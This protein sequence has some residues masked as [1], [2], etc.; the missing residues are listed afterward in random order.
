LRGLTVFSVPAVYEE[1]FGLYVI[2]AMACG[3]P[4]V[5]PDAAAFSEILAATGGGLAVPPRDA[6]ALALAWKKLLADPAQCMTFGEA[7]RLSVEKHFSARKMAEQ[8]NQVV[9]RLAPATT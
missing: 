9:S 1:A 5:Q 4:V 8:F 6:R 2:E 7:G 3:V